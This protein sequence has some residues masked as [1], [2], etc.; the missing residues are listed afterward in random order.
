MGECVVQMSSYRPIAT[1][2]FEI[3]TGRPVRVLAVPAR[4]RGKRDRHRRLPENVCPTAS[5]HCPRSRCATLAATST[6]CAN[7]RCGRARTISGSSSVRTLWCYGETGRLRRGRI[8]PLSRT[9][10]PDESSARTR[11]G[12]QPSSCMSFATR[13]EA[14]ALLWCGNSNRSKICDDEMR[15]KPSDPSLPR[16]VASVSRQ[17]SPRSAA[18]HAATLSW[19]RKDIRPVPP[20]QYTMVS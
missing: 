3:V 4:W 18:I 17:L 8:N 2:R 7:R 1:S 12:C 9:E 15:S 19:W 10:K 6:E 14:L 5:P 11:V 13:R 20:K 16:N